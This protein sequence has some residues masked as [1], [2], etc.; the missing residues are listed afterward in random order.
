MT[1]KIRSFDVNCATGVQVTMEGTCQVKIN[2]DDQIS[3]ELAAQN[4]IG[5]TEE[6][7]TNILSETMEG[8]QRSI[9]STMSVE[10][11]FKDR[12]TFSVKV[13][14]CATSDLMAMGVHLI[15]YTISS[16]ADANGYLKALAK[17]TIALVHRDARIGKAIC[18]RD[19]AIAEAE[20]VEMRDR[21][22]YETKIAIEEYKNTRD[23]IMES[24]AK[25]VNTANAIAKNAKRLARAE[26]YQNLIN[27]QLQV[28]LI[29]R[30]GEA[31]VMDEEVELQHKRLEACTLQNKAKKYTTEVSAKAAKQ[32]KILESEAVASEILMIGQAEAEA[33]K[34]KSEAEARATSM[35]AKAYERFGKAAMIGELVTMLP[36]IASEIARPVTEM[37]K[38]TIVATGQ[39]DIGFKRVT[40]E[41]MQ[42]MSEVPEG[43]NEI[44]GIDLKG[45]IQD[46]IRIQDNV[47]NFLRGQSKESVSKK[48]L[49]SPRQEKPRWQ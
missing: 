22:V 25:E 47:E 40:K 27:E 32:C 46:S 35:K 12:E 39:G 10:E 5:M 19:A 44:T 20:A 7:I 36:K 4:F 2:A 17:P 18:E 33:V 11:I 16:V 28:K 45:E 14:E 3:C 42:I 38:M 13:R 24:N 43:V 48:P 21:K 29:E 41:I 9:I 26:Y 31:R 1:L 37:N 49:D 34:I 23:L 8:H 30:Q 6:K 15:S